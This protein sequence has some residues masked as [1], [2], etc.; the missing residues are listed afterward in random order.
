M[1]RGKVLC[2]TSP[3]DGTLASLCFQAPERGGG[4][5][6]HHPAWL[7]AF[8]N[9]K[10]G[11]G[12]GGRSLRPDACC[13]RVSKSLSLAQ[14]SCCSLSLVS[15]VRSMQGSS[16]GTWTL[17]AGVMETRTEASRG[18]EPPRTLHT[19]SPESAGD[20]WYSRS[21][22]P[23]V[24]PGMGQS[25]RS[26]SKMSIKSLGR[27][28]AREPGSS[29]LSRCARHPQQGSQASLLG[30]AIQGSPSPHPRTNLS[31]PFHT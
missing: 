29:L 15:F 3:D 24:W 1:W 11:Q 9:I 27:L 18:P 20:T 16:P 6:P 26:R 30:R 22:E 4:T 25:Q 2:V 13:L 12:T 5:G 14:L 8:Y 17:E 21:L 23:W 10:G 31:L 19:Y 7:C 28:G